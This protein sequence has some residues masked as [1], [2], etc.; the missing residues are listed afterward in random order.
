M[1]KNSNTAIL[2]RRDYGRSGTRLSVIGFGGLA[3]SEM[4]Q[5]HANRVVAWAVERGVNYFDVAPTY[6]N[7]EE[8]L[9][10]A[11]APYRKDIFLACK[12]GERARAKAEPEFKR[13]LKNLRTDYFDLYQLHGLIELTKDVDAAF[14]KGGIMPWLIKA[15]ESGL[16]RHIGFSAHTTEAALAALDRYDFDSVLFPL[17]FVTWHRSRFGPEVVE[18]AQAKGAARLALK[19]L[20]RQ[21]WPPGEKERSPFKNCWYQ[22]IT[23]PHLA[24]LAIKFTLSLPVTAA[25]TPADETLV[26]LAVESAMK[27]KP[28]TKAEEAELKSLAETLNPLF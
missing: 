13:S 23:D 26:R 7:A 12:T 18:K 15:K 21:G 20:A 17:N 24:E 19:A 3:V 2:P 5:D 14:R 8:K 4:E 10:P 16:V 11:L 1:S 28:I 27:F 9:G 22:P 6:G 25:V